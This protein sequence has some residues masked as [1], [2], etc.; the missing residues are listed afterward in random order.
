MASELFYVC[1]PAKNR[2]C[3]K[4]KCKEKGGGCEITRKQE[5]ARTDRHGF[6]VIYGIRIE[7]EE[8]ENETGAHHPAGEDPGQDG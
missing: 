6:P 4:T 1:D 3:R 2:A 5:A 7:R 8:K